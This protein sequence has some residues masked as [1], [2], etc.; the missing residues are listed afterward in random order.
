MCTLTGHSGYLRKA[1]QRDST[2]ELLKESQHFV[3]SLEYGLWRMSTSSIDSWKVCILAV[4][5][6]AEALLKDM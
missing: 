6:T 3:K 4:L 5:S 1:T 2:Q